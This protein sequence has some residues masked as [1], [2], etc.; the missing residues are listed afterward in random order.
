[1]LDR[2]TCLS[3]CCLSLWRDRDILHVS[4]SW[5]TVC[6]THTHTHTWI[7]THIYTYTHTY[8]EPLSSTP[9][10]SAMQYRYVVIYRYMSI[11]IGIQSGSATRGCCIYRVT[12]NRSLPIN[13][14][15]T[16]TLLSS[17]VSEIFRSARIVF[18]IHL[19]IHTRRED[20]LGE[21]PACVCVCTYMAR[22]MKAPCISPCIRIW[23]RIKKS[24]RVSWKVHFRHMHM[25][26][27]LSAFAH[28]QF[29]SGISGSFAH[30]RFTFGFCKPGRQK[31]IDHIHG[32]KNLDLLVSVSENLY[33]KKK[34]SHT[35]HSYTQVCL[36]RWSNPPRFTAE[37]IKL[38]RQQMLAWCVCI[39][40]T[41]FFN[42]N[43]KCECVFFI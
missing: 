5:H 42:I 1:M 18:S 26:G 2:D 38:P 32:C 35:P 36:H 7:Y 9:S 11:F 16:T 12:F 24:K 20:F 23:L 40:D 13:T 37:H 8:L 27:S 10:D 43:Y 19:Y 3:L 29:T 22:W 34:L 15:N 21:I 4:R 30:E 25:K 33:I 39:L 41:I 6:Y 28:E 31:Q 14:A 17:S